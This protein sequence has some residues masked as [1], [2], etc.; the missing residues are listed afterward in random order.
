[1][2]QE[3][4]EVVIETQGA[5]K[6]ERVLRMLRE[7]SVNTRPLM[8]RL[9][10]AMVGIVDRNFEAEGRPTK[11]KKRSPL[12]QATLAVDAQNRARQTKRYKNAKRRGQASI[13]RRASLKAMGN[14]ILSR[15]GDLKKSITYEADVNSVAVGPAALFPTPASTSLA[16]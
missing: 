13:L 3:T 16:G 12:T 11:W 7:R 2:P 1:M 4:V 5:E 8:Q 15:E 6:I 9:G 14:K 10:V